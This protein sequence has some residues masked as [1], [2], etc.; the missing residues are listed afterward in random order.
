VVSRTSA[1]GEII[2]PDSGALAA[3]D[4]VAIAQAVSAV[5]SRPEDDRRAG[6]RRRAEMFTW[7]RAAVGMLST[8]GAAP[9]TDEFATDENTA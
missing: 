8:L 6:A 3:N 4:P 2:T 1:L 5:V 9:V 7:Q